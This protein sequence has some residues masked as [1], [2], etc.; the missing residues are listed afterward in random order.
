MKFKVDQ[1][2]TLLFAIGLLLPAVNCKHSSRNRDDVKFKEVQELFSTLPV[3][4]DFQD[5]GGGSTYSKSKSA[6]IH[7]H[8][9]SQ[10]R[11]EDVKMFYSTHLT[12]NGWRLTK[13][14]ALKDWLQDLGGRELRFQKGEY[15]VVIEYIGEKASDPDWEYG[16]SVGW[17]DKSR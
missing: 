17:D 5:I 15:R 11:F 13:D 7:K 1:V 6:S 12:K 4:N 8:Y 10:A 2:L 14:R 9:R 3:Y 16:V